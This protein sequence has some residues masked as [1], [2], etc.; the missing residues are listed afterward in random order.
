MKKSMMI[1]ITAAMIGFSSA[2]A[3]AD[4]RCPET[5]ASRGTMCNAQPEGRYECRNDRELKE[6]PAG[7]YTSAKKMSPT[8]GGMMNCGITG[9]AEPP[10]L[11]ESQSARIE[12]LRQK[13]FAIAATEREELTRLHHD[14]CRES[15]NSH[16]DK[17]KI[18]QIADRIGKQH[19]ALALLQ[20][21]HM[22]EIAS[23]LSPSQRESIQNMPACHPA[24]GNCD[25][26][27]K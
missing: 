21:A 27:S 26:T 14:L 9:M 5:G 6:C 22:E 4:T 17:R 3:A 8:C 7:P 1:A 13:Q 19:T 24:S 18:E 11:N 23:I 16:P 20:S 10:G 2:S 25:M 12:Q 15:L